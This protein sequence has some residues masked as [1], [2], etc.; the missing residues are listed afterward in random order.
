M[1]ELYV[2]F[3]G[4]HWMASSGDSYYDVD[5][6]QRYDKTLEERQ[7]LK[8]VALLIEDYIQQLIQQST[9]PRQAAPHLLTVSTP[10]MVATR[11][12]GAWKLGG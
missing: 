10:L 2:E 8:E 5:D 12:L 9:K 7:H 3:F 11:E 6:L 4:S 1:L